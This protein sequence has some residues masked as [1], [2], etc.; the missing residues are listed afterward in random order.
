MEVSRSKT[1]AVAGGVGDSSGPRLFVP[2]L[3]SKRRVE[4]FVLV[5][6]WLVSLIAF[7]QWWLQ[8]GHNAGD[9]RFA[10]NSLV[11]FWTTII[12]GYFVL[13]FARSIRANPDLPLPAGW[14]VAMVV[15]KAPSEPADVVKRTL[16][17]MLA[18]G[19][20]HDT[21][22]ADE[23]PTP[24]MI[25]WCRAHGVLLSTRRNIDDYHRPAWPRRTKSKEGNLAYFYDFHGYE[26]YDF[27][28]QMDADH[29]PADSYLEAM[30]RPFCDPRV[31]YV[32]AP[33]ICDSNARESWSAR[34]RLF[35]EGALHGALQTGHSGNLA[36]LCIGSHY[37]VRTSA[38]RAVGGLGPELAEDH[39]TT[40]IMNAGG[41]RGIH[42]IDAIAHGEGPPTFADL[43]TQEFQ[44]SRSLVTILLRYMPTYI[45]RLPWRLK[46]QFLF[47]QLWYPLFA[48]SMLTMVLIPIIAI[49]TQSPWANVLYIDFFLRISLVT[50]AIVVLMAWIRRQGWFRPA[51]AKVLSWEGALF[52]FARWP[53]A[54]LGTVAAVADWIRGR[55]FAFRVTPKG[56]G[57]RTPLPFA[58]VL[59]YLLISLAS[60]APMVLVG[61]AYGAEGFY[62]FCL[63]NS[64]LYLCIAAAIVLLHLREQGRRWPRLERRYREAVVFAAAL[65]LAVTGGVLRAQASIDGLFWGGSS[66]LRTV[67]ATILPTEPVD[68][69]STDPFPVRTAPGQKFALGVYD[70]NHAFQWADNVA[71]EHVFV[72]WLDDNSSSLAQ[73][74]SFARERNRWLMVTVEP[75]K[76]AETAAADL[77]AD[78]ERGRYDA[79]ID[80]LC[81]AMNSQGRPAFIR[82]GHEMEV[83]TERYPW[84]RPDAEGYLRAYRHFVDRCRQSFGQGYYVWSPRGDG[85]L[86]KYYPGRPFADY[87]GLS[88][89]SLPESDEKNFGYVR[90]FARNF[91]RKYAKVQEF[92]RPVMIAELGVLGG[93][94]D[95]RRWLAEAFADLSE[96]PL[97]QIVV[98]FN[99]KDSP[100]A[101][102][103]AY[104]LPDWT[105]PADSLRTM[106]AEGT[107]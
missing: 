21:W 98:Y 67:R 43:V 103:P 95:R 106:P 100:G 49:W 78:T 46:A 50:L 23:D 39:S 7:W 82:W 85:D 64:A 26:G 90:S 68:V 107:K 101:W 2:L 25:E 92:G 61:H 55:N 89:Y 15:T 20:P 104:G 42:A 9:V 44:W 94:E 54:L 87:V 3:G 77:F 71:I 5:T 14:R 97:L 48:F 19:Y 36:P 102:A 96:Y 8:P 32:S 65:F 81:K 24:E 91:G 99:A 31:G 28:V 45:G 66:T 33:S 88:V 93:A 80:R 47:A 29:V 83:A 17:A 16:R 74:D 62:A 58:L 56:D 11:L 41:W 37:A 57:T 70:P 72:S 12:P 60:S 63:I 51:E 38:L 105:L 1:L 73:T 79:R 52:L 69:R 86:R 76:D 13:V 40:L 53:W 22:L 6:V 27:V 18:Q 59:P 30:L 35:V 34:G 84:T 10:I 75:F 4:Y